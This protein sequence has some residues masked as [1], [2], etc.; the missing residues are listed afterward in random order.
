M[1]ALW[2]HLYVVLKDRKSNIVKYHCA[3]TIFSLLVSSKQQQALLL[4][5]LKPSILMFSLSSVARVERQSSS[6]GTRSMV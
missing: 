2:P 3:N 6:V 1:M 5:F 4:D